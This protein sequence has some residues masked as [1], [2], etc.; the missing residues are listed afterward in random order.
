MALWLQVSLWELWSLLLL[1]NL[2]EFFQWR[3]MTEYERKVYG[4]SLF[5]YTCF[6]SFILMNIF[7][8]NWN[9]FE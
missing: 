7:W 4:P 8:I 3:R 9:I 5:V 2:K 1:G 6:Y